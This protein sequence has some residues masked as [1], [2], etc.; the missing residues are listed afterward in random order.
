MLY[1]TLYEAEGDSKGSS[2]KTS[3][4]KDGQNYIPSSQL[5][6]CPICADINAK[7]EV[8]RKDK[9][10]SKYVA[11]AN[12]CYYCGL[13]VA[14]LLYKTRITLPGSILMEGYNTIDELSEEML[15]RELLLE[16]NAMKFLLEKGFL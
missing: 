9:T 1:Q 7:V 13:K 12:E 4:A 15:R 10:F 14:E 3:V 6:Y 8:L 11:L 2:F 5:W 16:L